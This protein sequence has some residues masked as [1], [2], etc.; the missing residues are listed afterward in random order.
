MAANK[1]DQKDQKEQDIE[2]SDQQAP[3]PARSPLK[4]V[5]LLGLVGVVVVGLSVGAT[6]FLSG[7]RG[8]PSGK[9]SEKAAAAEQSKKPLYL[10]LDPPFVVNFQD[11][12]QLH[13]LQVGVTVMAHHAAVIDAL[14]QSMPVI[15]NDL[16]MLFS[17]QDYATLSTRAGKEKLRTAS[18]ADIRRILNNESPGDAG[19]QAVY[20]TSFVMQ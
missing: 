6:L 8:A 15:R 19:V 5:L 7:A 14:K 16:V 18:L 3:P 10:A 20:F 13:F 11:Q 4:K 17:S 9:T 12:N 1:K 2:R